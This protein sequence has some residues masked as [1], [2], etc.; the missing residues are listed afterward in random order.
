MRVE[1]TW[2]IKKSIKAWVPNSIPSEIEK[3]YHT[4]GTLSIWIA[5]TV[6]I[7]MFILNALIVIILVVIGFILGFTSKKH[8]DR[9]G[10]WGYY[11]NLVLIIIIIIMMIA[12]AYVYYTGM[13]RY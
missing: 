6:I 7:T 1:I 3:K 13:M 12:T 11:I 4:I 2:K 5:L 8:G 9:N 10:K